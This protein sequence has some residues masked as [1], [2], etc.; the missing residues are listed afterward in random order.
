MKVTAIF[1]IGKTNKKNFLFDRQFQVVY[2]T[3]ACFEEGV[4]DDKYPCDDLGKLTQWMRKTFQATCSKP[5][6]EIQR[7]NFSAYGA[8]FVHLD[9]A[10]NPV[11]PLYNY[12]KPFPEDLWQSFYQKYGDELSIAKETASPPLGMLNSGLQL[13]WLKYTKPQ[14]FQKIRWSLHFPQFLSFLFTGIKVSDFTSIGCH[15]GLWDYAKNDYHHWVYAE[16][17]DRILPPIVDTSTSMNGNFESK[18]MKIGIGIH[19]SSSALLPYIRADKKPF[20]LILTGTWSITINPFS[21]DTLSE[22]DLQNDCLSYMQKDGKPVKASMLFLGNEYKIQVDK[23]HTHYSKDYDDH[24]KMEFDQNV[25]LKLK[26][27]Y[28]HYF[29]FESI[30][31]DRKQ[32]QKTS[33]KQFKTFKE[34]FHQL[35]LELMELQIQSVE[36]VIGNSDISKLYVD[37]GFADNQIYIG[38]LSNHFRNFKLLTTKSPLGSALGAAMVISDQEV[39][40]DFLIK[41]YG[42]KRHQPPICTN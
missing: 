11:T 23:L 32:P 5:E 4:D 18:K 24:R 21:N 25:Y 2:K 31:S 38:L 7:V 1:D 40:E 15:T 34:A 17:I 14:L 19:D 16:G 30:Q 42:L 36:R 6:F 26:E 9:E 39:G 20:L 13:Y 27:D 29:R 37:G 8:S 10:G 28:R 35:M 3:Y 22:E 12:L 33:L 41:S